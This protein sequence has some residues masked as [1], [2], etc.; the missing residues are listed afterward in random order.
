MCVASTTKAVLI[1]QGALVRV[2]GEGAKEER[3]TN[4]YS[5]LSVAINVSG[6]V[7]SCRDVAG[8]VKTASVVREE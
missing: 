2:V 7:E 1:P 8:I 4:L 5:D 6:N 3:H